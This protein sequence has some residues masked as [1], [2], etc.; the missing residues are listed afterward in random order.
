M[1]PSGLPGSNLRSPWARLAFGVL[2][3][4]WLGAAWLVLLNGGFHKTVKYSTETTFVGGLGGGFMA[5]LFLVLSFIAGLVASRGLAGERLWSGV[6]LAIVVVP[7]GV[8]KL[9]G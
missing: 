9:L 4:F 2:S 3:V 1:N 6:L 7:V 8:W 5:L